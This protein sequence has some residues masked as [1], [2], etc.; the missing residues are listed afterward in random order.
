MSIGFKMAFGDPLLGSICLNPKTLD[1][2]IGT[3][4]YYSEYCENVLQLNSIRQSSSSS[5]YFE[6]YL[7]NEGISFR[8]RD[9]TNINASIVSKENYT[10]LEM[11]S[12]NKNVIVRSSDQE[13]SLSLKDDRNNTLKISSKDTAFNV[14][15]LNMGDFKLLS[16]SNI[17]ATFPHL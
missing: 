14:D 1:L 7:Y 17:A 16:S 15:L 5:P 11:Q 4:K 8:A 12:P 13:A 6:S 10:S 9:N 3:N 2:S